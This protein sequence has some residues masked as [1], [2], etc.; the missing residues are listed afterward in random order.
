MTRAREALGTDADLSTAMGEYPRFPQAYAELKR[1]DVLNGTRSA[2][3]ARSPEDVLF[4]TS[5]VRRFWY[6]A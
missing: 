4:G 1:K 6:F 2:L 3:V 5:L